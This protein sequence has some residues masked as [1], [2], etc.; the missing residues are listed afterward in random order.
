MNIED[1]AT[2]LRA[3]GAERVSSAL[4]LNGYGM[5]PIAA[6]PTLPEAAL[7]T[8]SLRLSSPTG[9]PLQGRPVVI[10]SIRSGATYLDEGEAV[11]LDLVE[12]QST[13]Y[14]DAEGRASIRLAKGSRVRISVPGTS[15]T[16]E[17]TVPNSDFY[18]LDRGLPNDFADGLSSP[19]FAPRLIVRSDL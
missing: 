3:E 2:L 10:T 18:F 6:E 12:T 14:T 19:G 7:V 5:Y 17:V 11:A 4:A 13:F 8:G 15:L 1:L 9:F 16:R